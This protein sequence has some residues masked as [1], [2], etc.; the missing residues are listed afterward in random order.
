MDLGVEGYNKVQ[1][2]DKV[3]Y[4]QAWVDVTKENMGN[5]DF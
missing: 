4:G 2:K 3:V 1:L 5:Y